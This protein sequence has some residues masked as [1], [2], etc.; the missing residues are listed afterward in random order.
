MI[1]VRSTCS[2]T[3]TQWN[4]WQW[5][6]TWV[7]VLT[8]VAG[9]CRYALAAAAVI[10][11]ASIAIL[12]SRDGSLGGYPAQIRIGFLVLL[13]LGSLPYGGWLHLLQLGGTLS[14]CAIGY[15]PMHRVLLLMPWNRTRRLDWTL[16]RH[17][18]F[19]P[20]G[21]GGLVQLETGRKVMTSACVAG[22]TL[23]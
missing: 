1:R 7:L 11:L 15:C 2:S 21:A 18:L 12:R 23:G 3:L 17:S 20:P 14:M 9:V 6:V 5:A 16:I 13:L 10:C 4:W 22:G 19:S 8:A